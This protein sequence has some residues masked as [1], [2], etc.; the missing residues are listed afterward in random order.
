[1]NILTNSLKIK[2]IVVLCLISFHTY[3]S[4]GQSIVQRQKIINASNIDQLKLLAKFFRQNSLVEKEKA[5]KIAQQK[6]WKI[7]ITNPDGSISELM[8][9]TETGQPIYYTT[10]S[11]VNA[12]I[13]TR[14]NTLWTG[15]SL[16]LNL[17]GQ[18]MIVGE[19]DGGAT[20]LT[21]QEFGVRAIQRDGVVL[22]T[23]NGNT[24]HAT[25]VAGTLVATGV[26]ANSRGMA[27]QATLWTND[28]NTDETEMAT[29]ATN[30]LLLSNH[31]YGYNSSF[32]SQW[33]FGFYDA[34]A[35]DW[36][37]I[38]NNA[39][40]YLIVKAA[41]NDR[42]AGFNTGAPFGTTG[43]NLITGSA[44]SK[45]VLVVGAVNDVLSYT[46]AS[47]VTMSSF[48]SW[49]STDDGRIKPDVV[50][51][52][53]SLFSPVSTGNTDYG[54]LSGTSMASPNVTGTLLLLQQHYS[55]LNAGAFMRSAT[56]RGLAIHTADEAGANPGPD[57][58]F[59]WG[60]VNAERA[61]NL[62][63]NRGT[64]TVIDERTLNNG[65]SYNVNVEA[66]ASPLEV[67]ICWNDPAGTPLGGTPLN[68]TTPMLV[69]DLDVRI[70]DGTT[71]FLPWRLDPVNPTNA[72]TQGDNIRDNVEKITISN[73]TPGATYTITV[74]HK[75]TL[76]GASQAYSLIVSTIA[77]TGP[78]IIDFTSVNNNL[79]ENSAATIDCRG[80]QDINIPLK[81]SKIP[82]SNHV[83]NF[84]FSGTATNNQD[85]VLL[86]PTVTFPSGS[87]ANQNLVVRVYNDQAIE[88]LENGI[89][90]INS[91]SNGANIGINNSH[92]INIT[93]NDAVP[94]PLVAGSTLLSENFEGTVT[95]WNILTSIGGNN[96]WRIGNQR[97]L[98]GTNSAYISS[99]VATG[100]YNV[101]DDTD[102]FL[103]TPLIDATAFVN[104][105]LEVS[106]NF[107]C[108]GERDL[109]VSGTMRNWDYGV[110][111][112][113][114]E[115]APTV[116]VP[117][118]GNDLVSPYQGVTTTTARTVALPTALRG[119]RFHI[120]W[121]WIND[122]SLGSQPAFVID[123]VVVSALPSGTPIQTAT[124][125]APATAQQV[126]LGPNSTVFAYN[127]ANGNLIARI[128]NT[129]SHDYGCTQIYVDRAG[130]G[131]SQFTTTPTAEY[132][133]SKTIRVIP[134]NNNPTGAYNIRIYYTNA[135]VTGWETA[136]SQVRTNA[137]VNKTSGAISAAIIGTPSTAGSPTTQGT[138]GTDFWIEGGFTNGFSG[139]G[140]GLPPTPLP[141]KLVSLQ[142]IAEDNRVRIT[143]KTAS[144]INIDNF[145]VE[146][147]L[148]G[149]EFFAIG[150]VDASNN[151]SYILY[152]NQP[153]M[154]ENYYRL[155]IVETDKKYYF[156]NL[157][158]ANWGIGTVVNA[159]PNPA[160]DKLNIEITSFEDIQVQYRLMSSLGQVVLQGSQELSNRRSKTQELD[161]KGLAKGVY[162]LEV[163]NG[164]T[165]QQI[166]IVIQ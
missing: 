9:I 134:T 147:S 41:G 149:V 153:K 58:A 36:D 127:P 128:E 14:A 156:S 164:K 30:G 63:T 65:G 2:I 16:G 66:T 21:H 49:G 71:T 152:D 103:R 76:S 101:N 81:I 1:M 114:T 75:G 55:N 3:K 165:K 40:F 113:F 68:N 135:E 50:G 83:V 93:D 54:T 121:R 129:S 51:N 28:W 84:S 11:N 154:G 37:L 88:A 4:I 34:T 19:W 89:I 94:I 144:E 163:N 78:A 82:T 80:Y 13:S 45:N 122:T 120:G 133:A 7:F 10:Y 23:P 105:N 145:V 104:N 52:G 60:L 119:T 162:I 136:T 99:G 155:R 35:R 5:I 100:N 130:T 57:Y 38:A 140:M 139:L 48:S 160:S 17:N 143:W 86:T 61:A 72:A 118:E 12:A 20:R 24:D 117:I 161:V 116:F 138:Y 98:N 32:L 108:N 90:T 44:T 151:G 56:L 39:P 62:I 69:N 59:G 64:T 87:M 102:R 125:A 74:T 124:F 18:G 42:G 148:D 95:G 31:S 137:V 79:T 8:R 106:F 67:T 150:D 131:A 6:G 112:Y 141:V 73:P 91:I 159:Y 85:Y 96:T 110:L 29:E 146:K 46:N 142:A 47:S 109:D 123:N 115:A 43:Y 97:V 132:L 126:Y 77:N 166:K 53:V 107:Q 70:S 33:Q 158:S 25:H 27:N 22:G 92:S 157:V 15:G 111:G 26:S